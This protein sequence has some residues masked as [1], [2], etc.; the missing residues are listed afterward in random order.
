MRNGI[1]VTGFVFEQIV[2]YLRPQFNVCTEIQAT[3]LAGCDFY[4][5]YLCVYVCLFVCVCQR[6]VLSASIDAVE[7]AQR[8]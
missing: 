4:K 8:V 3:S 5:V 1:E 2:I 7:R 6:Q